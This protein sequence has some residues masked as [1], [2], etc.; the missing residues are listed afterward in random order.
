MGSNAHKR[1]MAAREKKRQ[2]EAT[3]GFGNGLPKVSKQSISNISVPE[4][5]TAN[6]GSA[7]NAGQD[8]GVRNPV[9]LINMGPIERKQLGQGRAVKI[10]EGNVIVILLPRK[11][12]LATST[13]GAT[14][15]N[16]SEEVHIPDGLG[17]PAIRL[18]LE[19]I[20][21]ATTKNKMFAPRIN[22]NLEEAIR[23][24]AV[25]NYLGMDYYVQ[26]IKAHHRKAI[27][28]YTP[29]ADVLSLVEKFAVSNDDDFVHFVAERIA[30]LIR[31][32]ELEDQEE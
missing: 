15:I 1:M 23:V 30:Y 19:W 25:A 16:A 8:H 5:S 13:K 17:K 11:L 10:M 18:L 32:D 14:I 20:S 2:E 22:R 12:F 29:D 21:G 27:M 3:A 28:R 31:K 9:D 26:H 6:D 7:T 4:T 24:C